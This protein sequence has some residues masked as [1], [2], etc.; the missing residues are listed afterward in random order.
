MTRE[1]GGCL[2]YFSLFRFVDDDLDDDFGGFNDDFDGLGD[3]FITTER[4]PIHSSA[5]CL[6]P[7]LPLNKST[8]YTI[9][10]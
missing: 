7:L 9:Q 6:P 10:S 4:P 3:D 5:P 8:I 1:N 2:P